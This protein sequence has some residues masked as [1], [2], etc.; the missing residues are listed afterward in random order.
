VTEAS[1][2]NRLNIRGNGQVLIAPEVPNQANL[3]KINQ[4]IREEF[5]ESIFCIDN[6]ILD[7]TARK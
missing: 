2:R 7:R 4:E 3:T 6:H 5:Q 1:W